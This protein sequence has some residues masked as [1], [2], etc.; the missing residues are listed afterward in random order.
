MHKSTY[1]KLSLWYQKQKAKKQ[2]RD[3]SFTEMITPM[4]WNLKEIKIW[5]FHYPEDE[6]CFLQLQ[7]SSNEHSL[8]KQDKA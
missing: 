6:S 7:F 3:K 8:S 5:Q 4:T 2:N 1:L